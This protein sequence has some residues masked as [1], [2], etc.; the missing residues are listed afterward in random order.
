MCNLNNLLTQQISKDSWEKP[1]SGDQ[2]I[3][4]YYSDI[5]RAKM[6]NEIETSIPSFC[7][8]CKDNF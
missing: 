7:N 1:F 2:G 8:M 6:Q 5:P 4:D 3:W